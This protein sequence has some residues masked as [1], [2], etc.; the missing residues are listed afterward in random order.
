M[1]QARITDPVL[2]DAGRLWTMSEREEATF[3]TEFGPTQSRVSVLVNVVNR[4]VPATQRELYLQLEA[5]YPVGV[6]DVFDAIQQV[7]K[8]YR[9]LQQDLSF[10]QIAILFRLV[11]IDIRVRVRSLQPTKCVLRYRYDTN[12]PDWYVVISED[13]RITACG[14]LD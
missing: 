5:W 9:E 10:D 1:S 3:E 6:Q 11:A 14:P 4:S 12:A 8:E 13:Y 2:G 7:V